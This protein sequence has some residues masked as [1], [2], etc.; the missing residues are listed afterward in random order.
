M[1]RFKSLGLVFI[2]N[3]LFYLI[4]ISLTHLIL[5]LIT[6]TISGEYL[7]YIH[8]NFID[9]FFVKRFSCHQGMARSQVVDSGDGL[10]TWRGSAN[11]LNKQ[12]RRANKGCYSGLRIWRGACNHSQ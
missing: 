3:V 9:S 11:T 5:T 8:T 12:S 10:Q 6:L 4:L 7:M 2:C 1:F